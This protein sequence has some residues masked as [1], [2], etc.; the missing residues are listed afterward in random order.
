MQVGC[1]KELDKIF[2]EGKNNVCNSHEF[3]KS[4]SQLKL[5]KLITILNMKE[6]NCKVRL[7]VKELYIKQ[8]LKAEAGKHINKEM[9]IGRQL[10]GAIIE[11]KCRAD[12]YMI[13]NE[14][15]QKIDKLKSLSITT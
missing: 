13:R 14:D 6:V 3:S 9:E 8:R 10:G 15:I 1:K 11:K 7:L 4:I 12:N 2:E 5:Q